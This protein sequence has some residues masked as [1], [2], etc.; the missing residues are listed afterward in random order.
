MLRFY[1]L[2]LFRS[3]IKQITFHY[4]FISNKPYTYVEK[5]T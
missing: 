3:T 4:V 1:T 2:H 5:K